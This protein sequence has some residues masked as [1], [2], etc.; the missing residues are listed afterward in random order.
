MALTDKPSLIKPKIGGD[1]DIWGGKLNE[2]I[3]KQDLFNQKI[4]EDSASQN[5]ELSRLEEEK[6]SRDELDTFVSEKVDNYIEVYGKAQIDEHIETVSK[7]DIKNYV[8][9]KKV[10]ISQ[11][12]ENTSKPEINSHVE[13]KKIELNE[14]NAVKKSELDEH[15]TLKEN[16]LD[17]HTKVKETQLDAYEKEKEK[18]LDA[19]N[20][21]KKSELT[22]HANSEIENITSHTNVKKS[23]I[24]DFTE[25]E[26]VEL[27]QHEKAKEA[28]LDT[29]TGKKKEELDSYTVVKKSEI[30]SHVDN[31]K[32]EL[33]AYE[34][35]KEGELDTHNAKKKE[36]L[37]A[38]EKVKE[39]ELDTHTNKKKE[40]IT[41]HTELEKTNITTHTNEKKDEIS[42]YT[43]SKKL[44]LDIHEKEKEKQLDT[45]TETKK[46]NIDK[47]TVIK[48]TELD[49][50][51]KAKESELNSFTLVK[52][53]A[54]NAYEKDKERELDSFTTTKKEEITTHTDEQI[55]RIVAMGID[56]K[57]DKTVY[58]SDKAILEEK[59]DSKVSND[60]YQNDKNTLEL[61]I[62][63]KVSKTG[64]TM[65][66]VLTI[67]DELPKIEFNDTRLSDS[68]GGY[69][70]CGSTMG[71]IQIL[72]KITGK[73]LDLHSNGNLLYN[74]YRIYSEEFKPTATD[75]GLEN[76]DNT[77]DG[78]KNVLSASK[79]TTPR[80]INGVAF[81][82]TSDIVIKA[83]P[84]AHNHNDIYYTKTETNDLLGIKADKS[85]V[86]SKVADLVDSAPE[87]LD[88][89]KELSTALGN[90][91]NF[92]TTITNKIA[93]VSNEA[94]LAYTKGEEAIGISNTKLDANGN[95]VSSSKLATPRTIK[96]GATGKAF[97]GTSDVLWSHAEMGVFKV[98][99]GSLGDFNAYRESGAYKIDK[100]HAHAP[101]GYEIHGTLFVAKGV[102][103]TLFQTYVNYTDPSAYWV[104]SGNNIMGLNGE[105]TGI[106]Q[107]WVRVYSEGYKPTKADV[108]LGNLQNW[109]VSSDVNANSSQQYAT[110][111][112]V[113]NTRT[114]ISGT[115]KD[116]TVGG[117]ANTYYPVQ[118]NV[119][120][121][122]PMFW[123]FS[124]SR[125]YSWTAPDTWNTPTHKGGLTLSMQWSGDGA[126]G[127]NDHSLRVVQ[128]SEQYTT[129]VA[130]LEL[131]KV[132]VVVWLRGGGA[133][134]KLSSETGANATV[135]VHLGNLTDSD[136][137]VF[138]PINPRSQ[139]TVDSTI[140]ARFPVRH[141]G[142]VYVGNNAVYH[143]GN[144]PTKAD[145]GLGA[146][147]NWGAS[148]AIGANS[149]TEYATTN[150]VAQ[151][152][153]EKLN[154]RS[155]D[156]WNDGSVIGSVVG[157][158]AWK[159]YGNG[160]TIFDA[161]QGISPTG[162]SVDKNNPNVAWSSSY[163][164]LMGWNGSNTYGVRVDIARK[165]ES[166]IGFDPN[167]IVRDGGSY[168]TVTFSNW[169]RAS[170]NSG[171]YFASYGGGWHMTDATWI[172][173]YN[174]KPIHVSGA[175]I[176]CT[177]NII[178]YYSDVRLKKNF[179]P[180]ND[181]LKTIM[182]VNPYYY[183]QN[184]FAKELGYNE[185]GK[186]Q[187]GFKAQEME[188]ILPQVV[189]E[190]PVNHRN[191]LSEETRAKIGDEPIKTIDYARITPLLWK[192][193][194]ELTDKVTSLE[195]EL[196]LLKAN[197]GK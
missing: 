29:H 192:A 30:D 76:V 171:I 149:T 185:E 95:A 52:K 114:L 130:R 148:S 1:P 122:S 80:R 110:T 145:I 190:A 20:V 153:A 24:N 189:Q 96:I 81:D 135:V 162:A 187:I 78:E 163:P 116:F 121:S 15:T 155:R 109:S 82:G 108:G 112:A 19:F 93:D 73:S 5:Q 49:E 92:A 103:D 28:E 105:V 160:H 75:I 6:L 4:I 183:E 17:S 31:K 106:W 69:I 174:N 169:V 71:V 68:S 150:M 3:D 86:D 140:M 154:N 126:W 9:S 8:D 134:Y 132:G 7:P 77:H 195:L 14:Y 136:G 13:K 194:Q 63:G 79:L 88:T 167:G 56:G 85:Y 37:D 55:E 118:I 39:G 177:N 41:S 87:T 179:K 94:K 120:G 191:D 91:P 74:G 45:H 182:S 119:N 151:V 35:V 175:D 180:V 65:T 173:S 43:D 36:E 113:Y 176:T 125:G 83:V 127:G 138:T 89:L 117:D 42:S 124:I 12:V 2:N 34:K 21:I 196:Q 48:K 90:D 139:G 107:N 98:D 61:N 158:L 159:N 111:S 18:E 137:A 164:T 27:N 26:K 178:A 146:V 97:D 47:H 144:K 33:D 170:G 166:L 152:R 51:E 165:A 181:A 32:L 172:R 53:E 184:D 131:L 57:V 22:A 143:A 193:V 50:Y 123:N 44:E 157:Q 141:D 67:E 64:D 99:T 10:E 133:Q 188:K 25:S 161:S 58:E 101:N 168:G 70:G 104:R 156:N 100:E 102:G 60:V 72:N 128:F 59:I 38:Y 23:E 142:Q 197:G 62:S 46:T 186:I 11:Y 84:E 129:M 54:L 66:G 147:N 115:A 40:E 16:Q